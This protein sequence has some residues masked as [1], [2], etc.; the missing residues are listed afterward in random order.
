MLVGLGNTARSTLL[1]LLSIQP[2]IQHQVRILKYKDQADNFIKDLNLI[3]MSL[4]NCQQRRIS[5]R[6]R[7]YRILCDSNG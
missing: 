4:L 6:S 1:C 5:G 3:L 2:E 7:R